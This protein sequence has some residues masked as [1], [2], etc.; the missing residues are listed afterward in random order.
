MTCRRSERAKKRD[1]NAFASE[2]EPGTRAPI[3]LGVS[4]S[5]IIDNALVGC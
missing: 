3:F 1:I 4:E 5:R 2:G